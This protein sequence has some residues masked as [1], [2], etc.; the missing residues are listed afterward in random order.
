M[1]VS[2][3]PRIKVYTGNGS[4][5]VFPYDFKILL[6]TDLKVTLYTIADG[7][8][9]VL[10]IGTDYTV[11]GVGV[12]TGGDVTLLITAPTSAKKIIIESIV[13][14]DQSLDLQESS[15]FPAENV[16]TALDKAAMRDQQ[17]QDQIDRCVSVPAGSDLDPEDIITSIQEAVGDAEAAQAAAETAQGLAEDARD[18][19]VA[20]QGLAEDARDAAQA[21]AAQFTKSTTPEAQ[22]GEEDTHYMTPLKTAQAIAAL[23]RALASQAEAEAGTDNT[24]DMTPLR[25]SQAIAALAITLKSFVGSFTRDLSTANNSVAYTGVG[26]RPKAMI[27]LG[28]KHGLMPGFAVISST[29]KGYAGQYASTSWA[30]SNDRSLRTFV[31]GSNDVGLDVTFDADGFTVAYTK[32]GSPT[33]TGTYYYLAIA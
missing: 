27:L 8:E 11:S 4:Q 20:A 33:G 13:P 6:N 19:S 16:E 29:A 31:D 15:S 25:V 7:T 3:T 21:A 12:L 32:N 1:A 10:D 23:Q 30:I 9:D 14:N 26:F 24:K 5:L 17:L 18:A 22:T 28:G 2:D